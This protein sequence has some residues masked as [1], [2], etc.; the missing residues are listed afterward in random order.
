MPATLSPQ[1]IRARSRER[2]EPSWLADARAEAFERHAKLE[3]PRWRRTDLA[4]LDVARLA[5]AAWARPPPRA[6]DAPKL[7]E[8]VTLLPLAVAAREHEDLVRPL[9]RVPASADKWEVLAAATW[10]EGRLLHVEK[11]VEARE[12][13]ALET[14]HPH[15]GALVRDAIR[16]ERSAKATVVA[17][18]TGAAGGAF[19]GLGVALDVGDGAQLAYASLQDV[20]RGATVLANRRARLHRD[21]RLAWT[22]GQFGAGTSVTV[23]E[24]SLAGPGS[25]LRFIGAF[26]G[27]AKQHLDVT[28]SA[29]LEAEHTAAQLDMKGALNDDGY[30]ANYSI[31]NIGPSA[32]NASGHQ[33]QETLILSERARADAIPKLDV[34]NND[35]SA[36]HGATVG[37]VDPEQM[38]YLRSRGFTETGAKRVIVAGFFEPLLREIPLDDARDAIERAILDRLGG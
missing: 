13:I 2:G 10:T 7:P 5:A 34:E 28:T 33:H 38:F 22:D 20:A 35:V 24:T 15:D 18:E 23:N 9:L 25:S 3:P 31:V 37:E 11:G 30:S 29:L 12:P 32:R 6:P 36:S 27:S 21:A 26:F 16:L 1:A 19:V 14:R 17:S 8:G 4:G